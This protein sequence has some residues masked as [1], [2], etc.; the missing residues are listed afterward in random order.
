MTIHFQ[1]LDKVRRDMETYLINGSR[2][3]VDVLKSEN[4][5]VD[6]IEHTE[7]DTSFLWR[8]LFSN[9]N[10]EIENITAGDPSCSCPFFRSTWVRAEWTSNILRQQ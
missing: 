9:F 1:L 4:V 5:P 8:S 10:E 7:V 6:E 2:V 3:R